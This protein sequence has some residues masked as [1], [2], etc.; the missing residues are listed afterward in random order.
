MSNP[1]VVPRILIRGGRVYDHE[2]DVHQPAEADILIAGEMIERLGQNLPADDGTEVIDGAGKLVLPGFVNAHYHS[3][4]VM[5]KGLF[6]EMPFDIWTL[7]SNPS[8][9]GPRSLEEVRLRTLVGA[10]ES[11]RNGITTIQ[12]FLTVVPQDEAMVDTVLSAYEEAGIRVVFAIAARDRASLDIAPFMPAD[13]PEAARRRVVG[14]DRNAKDELDFI[15]AQIKRLGL[16]PTPRQTWAL[17]ASAPQRCSQELL[18]GIAA[19]SRTHNLPVFTHV[20]ETRIQAASARRR[21]SVAS[22]LDVLAP[23]GLLTE[24][25][26]I[27]HGVW[28]TAREIAQI[29]EAGSCV[30]HNPVSNLKLKSGVAPI[31]DLH[32]AGIEIALGC[33]NYSCAETQNIFIAMRLLC[34]LPA[35]T[36]PEPGPVD[37][38]Y[39]LRAATLAGARAVGL[40]NSIG[41]IRP[42]MMAD[43]IILDLNEP[44]FVPFNSAARQIVF[45]ESGRAVETVLVSGRPIVRGGKLVTID[46][47]A[48]AAAVETIAP[49]FRRDAQ[50]LAA[51]NADL[52]APLLSASRKAWKVPLGFERYIGRG[53]S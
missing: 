16:R 20:Y 18:E 25:L 27:V 30:I 14:A 1:G 50:A 17:A 37:A 24:K 13:L 32:R 40:S 36:N 35:V 34:L 47:A 31:L 23:A 6:E 9:Y 7:H 21:P 10:A 26:G 29:A 39:A 22:L 33:D 11:L 5:A 53:S 52:A 41:A 45:S 3:H 38:A 15:A 49:T 43:L 2:G 44:S 51:R 48:L 4:D 12:D 42:G 19:L 28:L 46:E 8:N